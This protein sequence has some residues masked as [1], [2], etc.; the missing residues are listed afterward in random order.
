MLCVHV[1][2]CVCDS[3]YMIAAVWC[4]RH[5]AQRG[6]GSTFVT[7]NKVKI[8]FLGKST[9][10]VSSVGFSSTLQSSEPGVS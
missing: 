2:M 1:G 3:S 4:F 9:R 8:L 10:S 6:Q 5:R 7:H